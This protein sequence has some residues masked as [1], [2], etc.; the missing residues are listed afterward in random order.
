MR[1]I[2]LMPDGLWNLIDGGIGPVNLSPA[3]RSAA[4]VKAARS[5]KR[6]N[7]AIKANL[8]RGAL[9]RSLAAA[10]AARTRLMRGSE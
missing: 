1:A 4:A 10:K 8:T 5:K 2:Q 6:S 9:G 3:A 7:A